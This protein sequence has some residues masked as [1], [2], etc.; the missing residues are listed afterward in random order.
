LS[1][2]L[3]AS[4]A[5]CAH[6][7]RS[8]AAPERDPRY[9]AY[10]WDDSVIQKR[11]EIPVE[12]P[13]QGKFAW[14]VL[15]SEAGAGEV[16]LSKRN[17]LGL[18]SNFAGTSFEYLGQR[19]AS[20]EGFWQMMLYPEDRVDGK[21]DPR[22]S[23]GVSW[24]YTRAQVAQMVALDAKAAGDLASQN[25]KRLGIDWVSFA[26]KRFPYRLPR[27]QRGEHYRLIEGAMRAKLDQNASVRDVL[28]KTGDLK[29]RPDHHPEEG[30]PD[31][32]AYYD[33]WMEM[34]NPTLSRK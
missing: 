4:L 26:G 32:W 31:E 18:L 7:G 30:A 23:P 3:V 10:W 11:P 34:R 2:A 14:E 1:F 28:Q 19:Y 25:L 15:P 12:Y 27:G 21:A 20:V 22:R 6:A 24:K 13:T 29:L 9:P 5:G 8:L 17:E 33:V 16:I